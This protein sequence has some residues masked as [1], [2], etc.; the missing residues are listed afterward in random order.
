MLYSWYLA[1]DI[2]YL[3]YFIM[4]TTQIEISN[5]SNLGKGFS[6]TEKGKKIFVP[7][8]VTGDVV[9]VNIVQENSKFT[10]AEI[11]KIITPGEHRQK[12]ACEYFAECGGCSCTLT[13]ISRWLAHARFGCCS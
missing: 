7:K 3:S 12:A 1:I 2:D 4:N 6:V 8:T 13:P 5:I 11:V 9:E 10:L